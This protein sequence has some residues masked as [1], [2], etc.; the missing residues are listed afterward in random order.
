MSRRTA[1]LGNFLLL[2][3]PDSDTFKTQLPFH[4]ALHLP[5]DLNLA[6]ARPLEPFLSLLYQRLPCRPF[7]YCSSNHGRGHTRRHSLPHD[8]LAFSLQ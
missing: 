8:G 1:C 6:N 4:Y 7:S 3:S 5:R 2:A